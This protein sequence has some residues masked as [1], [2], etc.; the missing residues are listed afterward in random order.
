MLEIE[1]AVETARLARRETFPRGSNYMS[2]IGHPCDRRLVYART[3]WQDRIEP[4]AFL[5]GIFEDGNL[6]EGAVIEE[7]T[8]AG[9][10]ITEQ[11]MRFYDPTTKLS[12]KCDGR[13]RTG[14]RE[15]GYL[16]EVK[17]ISPISW[18]K[19]WTVKDMKESAYPW[20]RHWPYQLNLYMHFDRKAEPRPG[21]DQAV[22]ILKNKATGQLKAIWMDYEPE[23]AQEAIDRAT[24]VNQAIESG[25]VPDRVSVG[26]GLCKDCDFRLVCLPDIDLGDAAEIVTDQALEEMLKRREE[27]SEAATEYDAL[28]RAIKGTVRGR[29]VLVGDYHCT[30]TLTHKKAYQ[31]K[32]HDEWRVKILRL[33]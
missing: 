11:Q 29:N 18:Q 19:L 1:K 23:L 20:T 25:V 33:R 13:L 17:A 16:F 9:F 6:H 14:D 30:S 31:V 26:L 21:P 2:D 32:E 27:L 5:Q 4:S 8:K 7:L 3:H 24:R 22:F 28:D 12:G 15:T 10:L